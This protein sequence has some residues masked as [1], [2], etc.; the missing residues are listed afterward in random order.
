MNKKSLILLFFVPFF[1]FS[2]EAIID[3]NYENFIKIEP[4]VVFSS[5]ILTFDFEMAKEI[6][7]I[8][9][10]NNTVI[11][12]STFIKVKG[13]AMKKVDFSLL[14]KGIYL[15]EYYIDEKKVKQLTFSKL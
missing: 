6:T 8:L 9:S 1:L 12:T 5:A 13:K 2:Q 3:N 4:K 14:K 10:Y 15:V 7:Y 11:S